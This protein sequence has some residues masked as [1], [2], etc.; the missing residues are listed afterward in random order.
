MPAA[1]PTSRR[2]FLGALA[3]TPA[4]AI[5]DGPALAAS[6]PADPIF[7]L[8]TN[9]RAARQAWLAAETDYELVEVQLASY[10]EANKVRFEIG[11]CD[12]TKDGK[13]VHVDP[14]F[15]STVEELD[16]H[17]AAAE[18]E[19]IVIKIGSSEVCS[20]VAMKPGI[21]A[22]KVRA[23]L[24]EV[25]AGLAAEKQRLGLRAADDRVQ[26][27]HAAQSEAVDAVYATVPRTKEGALALIEVFREDFDGS[28]FEEEQTEMMLASIS[29]WLQG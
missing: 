4:I 25:E 5:T 15:A 13:V 9:W 26:V 28:L 27:A 6:A 8:I 11:T 22:A 14:R 1:S 23:A 16:R 17:V 12:H 24:E 7:P 19:P 3:A 10:R 18:E 29:A 20:R 2:R 21:D